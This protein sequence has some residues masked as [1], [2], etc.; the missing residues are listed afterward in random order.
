M[1]CKIDYCR[2][3]TYSRN[4][5]EPCPADQI[6]RSANLSTKGSVKMN[7]LA[8]VSK[9]NATVSSTSSSINGS[10]SQ[11]IGSSD[12]YSRYSVDSI[13]LDI[14]ENSKR[15]SVARNNSMK[16]EIH[17]ARLEDNRLPSMNSE[18][19]LS[20]TIGDVTLVFKI[21]WFIS[22]CAI[23]LNFMTVMIYWGLLFSY[24][25]ASPLFW[26]LRI[27]R[28][29]ISFLLVLIDHMLAR[30]PIRILHFIY[31]SLMMTLYGIAN[32]IFC[33]TTKKIVYSKLDFVDQ[34][35]VA[36]GFVALSV[37]GLSPLAHFVTYWCVY[38]LREKI[39]ASK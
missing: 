25:P 8:T 3:N 2:R 23:T 21:Y 19:F 1:C 6:T 38:R 29:G 27:D 36:S 35:V 14:E 16:N 39:F 31:P 37:F 10:T 17:H 20:E 12:A 4:A 30:T 15:L 33:I 9:K 18:V 22:T 7:N 11:L 32:G 13:I 26:Y 34:P 24:D 28:H 5:P